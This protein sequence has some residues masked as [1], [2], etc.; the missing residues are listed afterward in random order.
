MMKLEDVML[1]P[2]SLAWSGFVRAA[3]RARLDIDFVIHIG[4]NTGQELNF[5]SLAKVNTVQTNLTRWFMMN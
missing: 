4:A 5:Y 2:G 1:E 3:C